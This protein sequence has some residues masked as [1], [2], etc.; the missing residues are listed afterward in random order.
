MNDKNSN[1]D[2]VHK[3]IQTRL[4]VKPHIIN[5]ENE[6][7][8]VTCERACQ[9]AVSSFPDI[10][11]RVFYS[12]LEFI[13][14]KDIDKNAVR[15]LD[16]PRKQRLQFK[17]PESS[18]E[19]DTEETLST[20]STASCSDPNK[21]P[22]PKAALK[23]QKKLSQDSSVSDE[24]IVSSP[25]TAEGDTQTSLTVVPHVLEENEVAKIF[26]DALS[27]AINFSQAHA[28]K[29]ILAEQGNISNAEKNTL[30]ELVSKIKELSVSSEAKCN[31]YV[32]C[33]TKEPKSLNCTCSCK[34]ISE[35][36]GQEN[37]CLLCGCTVSELNNIKSLFSYLTTSDDKDIQTYPQEFLISTPVQ[38]SNV[39]S[40]SED[41]KDEPAEGSVLVD[42]KDVSP[43]EREVI[44]LAMINTLH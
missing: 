44:R 23:Q 38:T 41:G 8:L 14:Y 26:E 32:I 6:R 9:T 12:L 34:E 17:L 30:S 1:D 18:G 21:K 13:P 22:L 3:E 43:A 40:G 37:N 29:T 36:L 4:Q 39:K 2:K 27:Q 16:L 24:V 5:N 10:E 42:I 35:S 7:A 15:I 33:T 31:Y 28:S 11:D 20:G 19:E 25:S